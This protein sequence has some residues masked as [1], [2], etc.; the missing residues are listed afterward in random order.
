MDS[1]SGR[2]VDSMASRNEVCLVPRPVA[3]PLRALSSVITNLIRIASLPGS[4]N[5]A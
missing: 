2:K 3:G 5:N 4:R 1:K